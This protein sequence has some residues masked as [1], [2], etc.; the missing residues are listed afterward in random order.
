MISKFLLFPYYLTLKIRN[1][2]YDTGKLKSTRYDIPVLSVGNI[3]A[4]GTG[5]TPMV[6]LMLK[7][8]SEKSKVAV[9]SRGYKR[10]SKGFRLVNC[11]DSAEIVG[12]EPLQIKRKFPQA[13]VAVDI[14]R[15]NAIEQLLS[16]NQSE[17]PDIILL[18]DAMQYRKLIPS[19]TFALVDY[20]RPLF[21]D[22]LLPIGRLRDIPDQIRRA[23]TVILTKSPE[24]LN[25]WEI[26]RARQANRL[27]PEQ[28]LYFTKLHYCT[29]KAVFE[30]IGD[31]HYI[32]S[33]E[34]FLFSGI[35]DD[36]LILLHL[37]EKYEW[38]AHKR[39]SDHHSFTKHDINSL[40]RFAQK[41]PRTLLLTTEK[42]AQRLLHRDNLGD[43]VKKRLF[44]L[45]VETEFLTWDEYFRF[46][47][48]LLEYVPAKATEPQEEE[49]AEA[50]ASKQEEVPEMEQKESP[51]PQK[52]EKPGY[53]KPMEPVNGGLLF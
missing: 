34:V 47:K 23:E 27:R 6:E 39:F 50:A 46:Q 32:Y 14:E 45:P 16:L 22:E 21:K 43:D 12:D 4:G 28:N 41:H 11:D 1:H 25:E 52:E 33:K 8:L 29:P 51:E 3:A 7:I 9:L 18:D 26:G 19:E 36:K 13:I 17:R 5:K 31:N 38:I 30:G 40:R 42:D 20:N 10:K 2:L 44:Y 24:Y 48:A 35:A 15:T 49:K 53:L 37:S